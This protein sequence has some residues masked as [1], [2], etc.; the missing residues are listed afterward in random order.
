MV[1]CNTDND[2]DKEISYLNELRSYRLAGLLVIPAADSTI[3]SHLGPAGTSGPPVVCIG[4]SP[5]GWKGD[6]VLARN[7]EGAYRVAT[8]LLRAGH[9]QLGVITGPLHLTNAAERLKGF[10][11]AL[12]A[13]GVPLEPEYVQEARF[14]RQSGHEAAKRLLRMLPRPTAI[15]ACNDLMALGVLLAAR[16][17]NLRCPEDL[18]VVGFDI[19]DFTE[20][21][22]PSLTL[23]YQPGYQLV[24]RP[25]DCCCR[26]SMDRKAGRRDW[27][28]RRN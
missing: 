2:P 22:A 15:F 11:R 21:T 4:R 27:F 5:D 3:A 20:F 17:F 1:L 7:E 14:D 13:A 26:G 9:L 23:V 19:L 24:P 10:R 18:S 8:H 28:Y 6:M 12:D 16:E 25:P